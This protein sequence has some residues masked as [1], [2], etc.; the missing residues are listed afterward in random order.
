[1]AETGAVMQLRTRGGQTL[2]AREEPKDP[3]LSN[4]VP[5]VYHFAVPGDSL[6]RGG[7][8][9]LTVTTR[10]G[11]QLVAETSV[12][13]GVVAANPVAITYNRV[14]DTMFVQ[15][16]AS[17]GARSYMV[18]VETPYGPNIFFTDSTHV[19]LSGDLRN[20][21][22]TSLPHVF[23]PGFPQAVTV[24]AVDSNFYD[25][26]R[27][28][29][30]RISAEGLV[31]RVQGGLGVFG[32]LVRVHFDSLN[33]VAP[34]KEA[35]EGFF[36]FSGTQFERS[37][38]PN[39]TIVLYVESRS[40][41]SDQPDAVSG[42]YTR[43]PFLGLIGCST[44]GVLGTIKNGHIELAMLSD[45]FANDTA[46]YFIGS[47]RGDTLAGTYVRSGVAARYVRR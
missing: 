41:R 11:Q 40:A 26:F 5:G 36:D 46:D 2:M 42:R 4:G 28:H 33:V 10:N 22:V 8:Y 20:V 38:T 25:W 29:N 45:W 12:P 44:C 13:A 31:N 39:L 23:I 24:S 32:S 3:T 27:T 14:S 37:V 19:R 34:Q 18:R 16:P 1:M 15:W 30:N 21:D 43:R 7:T 9:R 35:Y 47:L 17:A 6:Q